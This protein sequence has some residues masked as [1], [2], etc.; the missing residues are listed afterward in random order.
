MESVKDKVLEADPISESNS[1][2]SQGQGNM[3]SPYC[4]Y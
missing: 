4:K 3:L 1:T 2:T